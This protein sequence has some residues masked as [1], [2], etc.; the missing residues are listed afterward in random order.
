[1]LV[2]STPHK[3]G[4]SVDCP[5]PPFTPPSLPVCVLQRKRWGRGDGGDRG[6]YCGRGVKGQKARKGM[7]ASHLAAEHM[8][9]TL[10][11]QPE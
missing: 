6:T 8:P 2:F 9:C 3:H 10:W 5:P 1:L 11:A 4:L 7:S